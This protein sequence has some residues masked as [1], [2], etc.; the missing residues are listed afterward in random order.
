MIY[1]N[2]FFVMLSSTIGHN[3]Q[4]QKQQ[5]FFQKKNLPMDQ[6]GNL[7]QIVPTLW[8]FISHDPL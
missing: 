8:N 3:R 6:M 5:P 4:R 2:D 1:S 7:D